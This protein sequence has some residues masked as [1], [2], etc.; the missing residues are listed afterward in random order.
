LPFAALAACQGPNADAS[1]FGTATGVPGTS[2]ASPT[3]TTGTGSTSGH[4][5]EDSSESA[6]G[7]VGETTA[8]VLDVGLMPDLMTPQPIGCKGK[9]D[10]LFMMSGQAFMAERQ[11]Q[12]VDAFPKFINTIETKFADFDY[13]IMVVDGDRTWGLPT[14][15]EECP[16]IDPA[17]PCSLKDVYPC[18][19]LHSITACD[20]TLG[21]GTLFNAGSVS[22]N[23]PCDVVGGHRYLTKSHPELAD[24]FACLARRGESGGDRLCQALTAAVS[25][26]LN[27]PGGCNDGFLRDDALLV[28]TFVTASPDYDSVGTPDEW[29]KAVLD[30]KH[31][32][33]NAIVMFGLVH[34]LSQE[35]CLTYGKHPICAFISRFPYHYTESSSIADYGP[36][37]DVATDMVKEACDAFIPG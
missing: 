3:T 2:G 35:W 14:C 23:A 25:P 9:I 8:P 10:F 27:G 20:E 18:E 24:T 34:Q 32:D 21:A 15:N 6:G 29:E 31:G 13:H 37:F 17:P 12:L 36:A 28:V 5:D 33:A 22:P 1:G 19:A 7:S 11:E 26:E 16:N 30:A 4:V